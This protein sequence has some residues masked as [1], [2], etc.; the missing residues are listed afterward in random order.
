MSMLHDK[1]SRSE[2]L[3][4]QKNR[5]VAQVTL[6]NNSSSFPA[7]DDSSTT[8][9]G[10]VFPA[11]SVLGLCNQMTLACGYVWSYDMCFLTLTA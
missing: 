3:G 11:D 4:V 6:S 10:G 2:K 1:G 7:H 9:A 8:R 5:P